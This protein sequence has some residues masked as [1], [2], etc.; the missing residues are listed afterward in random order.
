[1][2]EQINVIAHTD[3]TVLL[4]GESGSGKELFARAIHDLSRRKN[5]PFVRLNCAGLTENLLESEL[6]GPW[7]GSS[8]GPR[9]Q[10]KGCFE[11]ADAGTL[12]FD[13]IGALSPHLQTRLLHVLQDGGFERGG[14]QTVKVDVRFVFATNRNLES[15]VERGDFRADLYY[16]INVVPILLPPLRERPEDIGLLAQEFLRL[17]NEENG[18][19]KILSEAA[20]RRLQGCWFP[21]NV[22]ELENCVRRAAALSRAESIGDEDFAC[23]NNSCLS[24]TLW[25]DFE[26]DMPAPRQG[27]ANGADP[28]R[29]RRRRF[30]VRPRKTRQ[31]NG[32]SR[33]GAGQGC[34]PA[35]SDAAPDRLCAGQASNPGQEI[36]APKLQLQNSKAFQGRH[37]E[38]SK[39]IHPG[40]NRKPWTASLRSQ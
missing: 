20:L 18:T 21:G 29:V 3:T 19:R 39:A 31:R 37:C 16:R 23:S 38:R 2:F 5:E 14:S 6:F 34:A 36:L 35:Q 13:E 1:M 7:K 9:S 8:T 22:R 15:A 4:R 25:R 10:R 26:P 30:R 24:S 32:K 33:L 28:G 17:F 40:H 12:Y 11:R 27:A